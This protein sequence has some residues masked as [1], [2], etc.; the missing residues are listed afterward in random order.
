MNKLITGACV[1]ASTSFVYAQEIDEQKFDIITKQQCGPS[2]IMFWEA[3]DLGEQPLFQGRTVIF[4][5][6]DVPV[7]GEMLFT[8]NQDTG[9]WSLFAVFEDDTVCLVSF[10][11]AF[12]PVIN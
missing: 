2:M 9:Y 11:N 3:M 7:V 12:A 4:T 5:I 6:N 8:V 10:G 1:L